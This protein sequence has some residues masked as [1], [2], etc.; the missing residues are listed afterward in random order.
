MEVSGAIVVYNE[1]KVLRRALESLKRVCN[2][3]VLFDSYST[4]STLQ[5]AESY[6]CRI[7][8]HEFDNHRDQKNRAI[9]QCKNQWIILLDAD[10]YLS[11]ALTAMIPGLTDNTEGVDAWTCARYNILDGY[12]PV[13]WPDYQTRIFKNYVRHGGNP[14]HHETNVNSKLQGI[15]EWPKD[16]NVNTWSVPMIYHDKD[17]E[18]QKRQNRLYYSIRPGDYRNGPPEGAEDIVLD[19]NTDPN[20]FDVNVYQEYI[21]KHGQIS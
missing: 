4:D 12:G 6:G 5:I 19:P 17:K 20:R 13:G 7:Y 11:N 18:R 8:Q 15:V 2:E 21:K 9:E 14:F 16:A 3:I 10:E 1:S